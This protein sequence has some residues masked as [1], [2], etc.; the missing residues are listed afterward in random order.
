MKRGFAFFV[1]LSIFV[2]TMF[3]GCN[4]KPASTIRLSEVTHSVF[5][6][7]QYVALA[8]GF[9]EEEGLQ[10][11]VTTA[12]GGDKAMTALLSNNADIALIGPESTLYVYNQQKEDYVINFAQLTQKAGNFLISRDLNE[13]FNWSH[14]KGK[15]ILGARPGGMP[16]MVLEYI[17]K[18]NKI[19]PFKDVKIITNIDFAAAPG[20]FK[21][22]TGDY[23]ALFE[24]SGTILEKQKVGKVVASLGVDS[25]NIPYTVYMA[26][27]SYILKHPTQV[28]KFTNAIYKGQRW[29]AAHSAEEIAKVIAP[30][31]KE[32]DSQSLITIVE[33]YKTQNTW[34]V[35][36][37]FEKASLDLL[38]DVIT[39]AGELKQKVPY[40]K[41]VNTT[42]AQKAVET[43]K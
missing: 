7:P 29:V 12:F 17:L 28:Q 33:R 14:V 5:Y 19:Q 23:V 40:E 41:I 39:E 20:A 35:T 6:A 10:V 36:P 16:Q 38:Q 13:K 24:P 32:L 25:G 4:K 2:V 34:P 21:G 42:F 11:E 15:T 31:F 26:K 1:I 43:I 27:K 3:T 22:G 8:K 30:Y 18:K 9:F 37:Y